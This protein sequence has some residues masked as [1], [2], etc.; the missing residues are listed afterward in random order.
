MFH[1][2]DVSY[3]W[4]TY[5]RKQ[6]FLLM[7]YSVFHSRGRKTSMHTRTS[8]VSGGSLATS[9]LISADRNLHYL[10]SLLVQQKFLGERK[11]KKLQDPLIT[12]QTINQ[13]CAKYWYWK[14][15]SYGCRFL[16]EMLSKTSV[17]MPRHHSWQLQGTMVTAVH[18]L[19]PLRRSDPP[20]HPDRHL[21]APCGRSGWITT[22][23]LGNHFCSCAIVLFTGCITS[24]LLRQACS[25]H[26]PL[27]AWLG[28]CLPH[29]AAHVRLWDSKSQSL[30]SG[31]LYLAAGFQ[32]PSQTELIYSPSRSRRKHSL[33]LYCISFPLIFLVADCIE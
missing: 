19:F 8:Y 29:D 5:R 6:I 3:L 26:V 17:V 2:S 21:Q 13:S 23:F 7:K 1:V 16:A 10:A 25:V 33:P 28:K 12:L 9:V 20:L 27:E 14:A 11:K 30:A 31:I 15:S 32:N 18:Q 24:R 22:A 4:K